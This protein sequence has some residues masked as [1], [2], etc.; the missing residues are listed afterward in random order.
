[1]IERLKN[2]YILSVLLTGLFSLFIFGGYLIGLHQLPSHGFFRRV[3]LNVFGRFFER[4]SQPED[5]VIGHYDSIF[6]RLYNK[7][8]NIT[9]RLTRDG[10][11][12]GMT[13]FG[14]DILLLTYNGQIFQTNSVN[15]IRDTKIITPDNGFTAY[16]HVSKTEPYNQY[17]H[18]FRL[19]RYNDIMYYD[20]EENRGL[21]I[22]YSEFDSTQTCYRNTVATLTIEEGI[23]SVDQVSAQATDWQIIYRSQ[24]CLPLKREHTAI[25]GGL[26]GGRMAFHPP[27]SIFLGNGDYEW[28]GINSPR[29]IAQDPNGEYGKIMHIDLDSGK[30]SIYA[31]GVRNPQGIIFDK[32]GALWT[33]EHGLRGGDELNHI[34][35]NGN[36]GWPVESLGTRYSR[37][38]I[39]GIREESYGHHNSY[40]APV[41]AWLP[42]V[43][44]SNLT[45]INGFHPSWDGDLLMGSLKSMSLYR[46]RI[47]DNRT[48][49]TE[50]IEIGERIRYVHQHTDGRIVLWTDNKNLIFLDGK[51]YT[52][53]F[54]TDYLEAQINNPELREKV[55]STI[56]ACR[57]CHSI[58][59]NDNSTA[60]SLSTVFDTEIASSNYNAYSQALKS[61]DGVWTPENLRIFLQ[62]PQEFAPGTTMPNPGINDASMMDEVI[63]LLE[64]L[65]TKTRADLRQ[66]SW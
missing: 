53:N 9:D 34:E 33:V 20:S 10:R 30:S 60:P 62:D 38:P 27:A 19:F 37:L 23:E 7:K 56:D 18:K 29:A 57:Q 36:Y 47:K 54:V 32:N 6:L 5:E 2:K 11:G 3:E 40:T 51:P 45:L 35:E 24:P 26:A 59:P 61:R 16:E 65:N 17:T 44:I 21:A 58:E 50:K 15:D 48:L 49:F 42:S 43:A 63:K 25:D 8:V 1:M 66:S 55:K 22:S 4:I 41:F 12:G 39:P 31:T 28:D 52:D 13:S 14:D 64:A 46:I